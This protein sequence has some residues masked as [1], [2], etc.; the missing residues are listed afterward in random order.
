MKT[1]C[2]GRCDIG[3]QRPL[4]VQEFSQLSNETRAAIALLEE[5]AWLCENCGSVYVASESEAVS[6]KTNYRL[7]VSLSDISA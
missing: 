4:G 6:G 5:T 7:L 3:I 1:G 2:P